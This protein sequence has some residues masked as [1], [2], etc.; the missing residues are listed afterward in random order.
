MKS[1]PDKYNSQNL[2][3][4]PLL[5][6]NVEIH[7]KISKPKMLQKKILIFLYINKRKDPNESIIIGAN[8]IITKNNELD[9]MLNYLIF[10]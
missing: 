5:V 2:F 9:F 1:A 7:S 8:C 4:N 3:W 10:H 6:M